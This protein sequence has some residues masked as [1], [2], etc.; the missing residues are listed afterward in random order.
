M[1]SCYI[2][3]KQNTWKDYTPTANTSW[4][5]R[6]I[7]QVKELMKD[8]VF[9]SARNTQ[10]Y[11]V[12]QGYKW[13]VPDVEDVW[14]HPWST[15]RWVVPKHGFVA[16]VMA[17]GKLLTQDRLQRLQLTQTN[18]CFLCGVAAEDHSHLFFQCA[19]SE[20]CC[21]LISDWCKVRLPTQDC[22]QWWISARYRSLGMKQIIGVIL[23]SL[24]YHIWMCRNT[25][26]CDQVVLRP[27]LLVLKVKNDVC[28]RLSCC[29]LGRKSVSVT[30]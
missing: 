25:S 28:S 19:Y 24:V 21:K 5:W 23:T 20:I 26:R 14:W 10:R 29:N 17:H 3:I 12:S 15:N 13:L 27:D 18:Q 11:S 1:G 16:W 9:D 6:K 2:Y 7:C 22:V 30:K 8:Y 4:A